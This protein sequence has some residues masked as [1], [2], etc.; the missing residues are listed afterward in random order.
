VDFAAVDYFS[1]PGLVD[2]PYPY[3]EWLRARCPV[4]HLGKHAAVMVT[5]YDDAVS[6]M[7]NNDDYSRVNAVGGPFPGIPVEAGID[8][9]SELIEEDRHTYPLADHMATFDPPDHDKH[10]HLITRLLT[11]KRLE[12]SEEFLWGLADREIDGWLERGRCEFVDDYAVP[13]ATLTIA[14]LLGVPEADHWKFR[15][16]FDTGVAGN[17]DGSTYT[18]GH[19]TGL[20]DW[21][22]DYITDRRANPRSDMLTEIA[23]AT[24]ADGTLPELKDTVSLATF[25]FAAGRGTTVMLLATMLRFIGEDPALQQTL[26]ANRDKIPNFVEECLRLEAPIKANYRLARRSHELSGVGVQAGESI[27]ML[28]GA[29]NRDPGRFDNPNELDLERSN[30]REHITFGRGIG[31]CPGGSLARAEARITLNR[32][33]DRMGDIRVA[34]TEHGP[35]GDRRYSYEPSYFLRRMTELHIEFTPIG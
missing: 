13:F 34:E 25:F 27:V 23:L 3:G 33:L 19:S 18:G 8:D 30:A 11:P 1:E 6:V 35:A 26:R 14:D 7:R 21:F 5:G 4:H 22:V 31:A 17:V 12:G 15:D 2:D 16:A 32:V 20:V 10:R 28:L 29:C 24:F 9:V